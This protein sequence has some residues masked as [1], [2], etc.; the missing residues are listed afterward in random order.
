[1][2]KNLIEQTE[3]KLKL[4]QTTKELWIILA[5]QVEVEKVKI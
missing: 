3:L 1:M 2:T 4:N 5:S